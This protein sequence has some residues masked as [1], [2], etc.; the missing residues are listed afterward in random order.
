MLEGLY[1]IKLIEQQ[2]SKYTYQIKVNVH[3]EIFEGHFPG[4]P[5]LPGVA[6]LYLT[7]TIQEQ[8]KNTAVHFSEASQ[9]KFLNLVDP[10]VNSEFEY[11]HE[12]V[13]KPN[14][15]EMVKADLKHGDITFFKINAKYTS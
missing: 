11:I 10:R 1:D 9:I 7:R 5:V 4:Q 12:I 3:H 8:I 6:M 15:E 2:S 14:G 13:I